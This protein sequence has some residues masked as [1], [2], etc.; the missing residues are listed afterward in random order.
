MRVYFGR[1]VETDLEKEGRPLVEGS[2]L[3]QIKLKANV[4]VCLVGLVVCIPKGIDTDAELR[5]QHDVTQH[6]SIEETN[7][8][9]LSFSF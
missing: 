2:D 6:S 8:M 4:C 5:S 9:L 1:V 7:G 3:S